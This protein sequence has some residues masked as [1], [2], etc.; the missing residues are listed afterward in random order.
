MT[1][2]GDGTEV[3]AT[4]GNVSPRKGVVVG[5]LNVGVRVKEGIAVA[6]SCVAVGDICGTG[7]L[8]SQGVLVELVALIEILSSGVWIS[9]LG[10][11]SSH[12]LNAKTRHM[13]NTIQDHVRTEH[14]FMSSPIRNLLTTQQYH[15]PSGE[16]NSSCS[17]A[18]VITVCLLHGNSQ[19][20]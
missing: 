17:K 11:V 9:G 15:M 13:V 6:G 19:S 10:V 7:V 3:P 18:F 5:E 12:P 4:T 8:T 16:H 2:I 20:S 14:C 1:A